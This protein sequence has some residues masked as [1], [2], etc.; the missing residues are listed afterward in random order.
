MLLYRFNDLLIDK[1]I[2]H[3]PREV[4]VKAVPLGAYKELAMIGLPCLLIDLLDALKFTLG[5]FKGL[6]VIVNTVD[7]DQIARRNQRGEIGH[8]KIM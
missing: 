8:L 6:Q 3:I 5:S 1:R 2:K 7:S 4:S